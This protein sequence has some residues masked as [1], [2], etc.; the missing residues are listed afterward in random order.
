MLKTITIT[1][2]LSLSLSLALPLLL[3]GCTQQLVADQQPVN[4]AVQTV[5]WDKMVAM[6]NTGAYQTV[7]QQHDKTVRLV[8]NNGQVLQAQEPNIDDINKVV[9]SCEKCANKPFLSE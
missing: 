7:G 5:S 8:L 2:T 1:I 9:R 6:V 3:I 4:Q